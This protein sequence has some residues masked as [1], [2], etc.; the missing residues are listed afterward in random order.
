MLKSISIKNYAIIDDLNVDWQ[1]GLTA[2]TGETGAGKSIMIGA[3]QFVLGARADTKILRNQNEKCI[4]EVCF[5]QLNN[6]KPFI[7][8]FLDDPNDDDLILRR[9]ITPAGKSRTFINDSPALVQDLQELAPLLINIH[10]QFDQLDLLT[11]AKQFELLD[12]FGQNQFKSLEYQKQYAEYVS[13]LKDI[14]DLEKKYAAQLVEQDFI[15]FQFKELD[16]AQLNSEEYKLLEDELNIASK[17]EEIVQNIQQ[18]LLL[19]DTEK[20]IVDQ[21]QECAGLLKNIR[22]DAQ[23]EEYYQSLLNFKEEF[24]ELTSGLERMKD[25]MDFDPAKLNRMQERH[26]QLTR[27]CQKYRV[28][29]MDEL[30]NI[31]KSLD[32]KLANFE[33]LDQEITNLKNKNKIIET[34]LIEKSMFLRKARVK[35]S[36]ALEKS[37]TILLQKLGMEYA[38]F[39]IRLIE[40]ELPN[41]YGMDRLEYLFSANKGSEPKPIKNQASGGE[42]SRL[43]LAI[44][45]IVASNTNLP[46][47]VFDEIDSG[48]SGQI[49]LQMGSILRQ[50]ASEH[51]VIT[52]THSA[53]IAS[54]AEHHYFVYKDTK[55]ETTN[56]K[57]KL[58][59]PNERMIEIA[60]MLSG[61]PPTDSA[62]KNAKELINI[63]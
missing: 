58:L 11:E 38:K 35:N 60:K 7:G 13:S 46:T 41:T 31:Q 49:A 48:V 6:L 12:A 62:L 33:E 20:G 18:I 61:D 24:K 3:L 23:L 47:L 54:R 25:K 50:M 5:N 57:L 19:A 34:E 14:S 63:N 26:D 44:K 16:Q 29:S 59:N 40:T 52:I 21:I 42:I 43:N 45:S 30:M 8:K 53:Q 4:V 55:S 10:Q 2:I 51:Q 17:S 28:Q 22:L 9:E 32:E 27:L 36:P 1:K 39:E 15:L 37:I 56:T